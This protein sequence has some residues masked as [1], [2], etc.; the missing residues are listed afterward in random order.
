MFV[1]IPVKQKCQ[2]LSCDTLVANERYSGT[3]R[4]PIFFNFQSG[5]SLFFCLGRQTFMFVGRCPR[6]CV[7]ECILIT[8]NTNRDIFILCLLIN[9][10]VTFLA[11]YAWPRT[12]STKITRKE[13]RNVNTFTAQHARAATR[14]TKSDRKWRHVALATA[15]PIL[16]ANNMA[17]SKA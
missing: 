1:S 9:G 15:G 10:N 11:Y 12:P 2:I 5:S 17:A 3:H 6:L 8:C 7:V 14:S 16:V 4:N 13:I